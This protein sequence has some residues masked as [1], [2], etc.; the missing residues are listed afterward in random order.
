[1]VNSSNLRNNNLKHGGLQH[2]FGT[3]FVVT[4]LAKLSFYIF[5]AYLN[6]HCQYICFSGSEHPIVLKPHG[7]SKN[8][9]LYTATKPSV[10]SKMKQQLGKTSCQK[11]FDKS[12]EDA[13]GLFGCNNHTDFIRNRKQIWNQSY[14]NKNTS[15]G[16]E[17]LNILDLHTKDGSPIIGIHHLGIQGSSKTAR[18]GSFAVTLATKFQ[19]DCL[20]Q[21]CCKDNFKVL[22]VDM[23]Y[24]CGGLWVTHLLLFT[25]LCYCT[26]EI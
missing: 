8:H 1:M 9:D 10:Q 14:T 11:I 6:M 19:L 17:F 13:G 2:T 18:T 25:I 5:Q 22:G 15:K 16:D 20:E 12:F 26:G 21:F 7:N 4:S 23:T 3:K 24:N